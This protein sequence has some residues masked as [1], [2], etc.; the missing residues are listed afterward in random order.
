MKKI[1]IPLMAVS[2]MLTSCG[3]STEL[4]NSNKKAGNKPPAVGADKEN[5]SQE[6]NNNGNRYMIICIAVSVVVAMLLSFIYGM[7]VHSAWIANIPTNF[8]FTY[9]CNFATNGWS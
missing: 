8:L 4:L 3:K 1:I 5:L 6:I 2:I 7:R 9:I